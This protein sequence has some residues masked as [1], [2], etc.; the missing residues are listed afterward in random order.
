MEAVSKIM[1][2][3]D[4]FFQL[5]WSRSE[6]LV[7]S[8]VRRAE[9]GG[10]KAIVVTL[11]TTVLGWRTWDLDHAYLPFLHGRGLAQYVSDQVFRRLLNQPEAS[12]PK[13]RTNLALIRALIGMSMRAPGSL[14]RNLRSQ[15][16]LH[17]IR[18]FISIYTNPALQWS[19]LPRLRHMTKLPIVLKG[20][21]HPDDAKKAADMGVDAIVVS[22]HGG[23]Q[24]DGAVSSLE[25][26]IRIR[27]LLGASM[28]LL[29]D[30]GIRSGADAFKALALGATAV[31]IG[32]PYVYALAVAG[33][34]GVKTLIEGYKA[35]LE[36]TMTLSGCRDVAAM[37]EHCLSRTLF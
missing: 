18:K 7:Q 2:G 6:D 14:I 34:E 5:Y 12:G 21:V 35:E 24:V 16:P 20:I 32:R 11:D 13:P 1:H 19:D 31:G 8:L 26:L 28:P 25:A 15:E 30:S 23:R 37:G 22:N 36:L 9:S 3:A 27:Q 29:L 4:W 33:P 17:A 10:S